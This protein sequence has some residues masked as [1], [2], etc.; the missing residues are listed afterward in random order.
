MGQ[1]VN[2]VAFRC[3]V[4]ET[5]KSRWYASKAEFADFLLEDKKIR[6]FVAKHPTQNYKAAGIDKIEIERTRDEV[7]VTLFVAGRVFAEVVEATDYEDGKRTALA[8]NP[9]AKVVSV[10]A[11]IGN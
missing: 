3:G 5:W 9:T 7:K 1:K 2:P 6:D 4:M 10:T 11:V 8:R